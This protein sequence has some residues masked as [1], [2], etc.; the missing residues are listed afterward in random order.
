MKIK[1]LTTRKFVEIDNPQLFYSYSMP[2]LWTT[3]NKVL[4]FQFLAFD[5]TFLTKK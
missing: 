2:N 4:N 5:N 3:Y 1:T